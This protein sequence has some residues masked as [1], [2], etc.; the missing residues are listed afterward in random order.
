MSEPTSLTRR[1]ARARDA[2]RARLEALA[3]T[4]AILQAA[5]DAIVTI[6]ARGAVQSFNPA[7]ERMFGYDAGEVI[8]RNVSLLMPPP[9]REEHDGYL[10]RYL[11]TGEQRI[12]GIGREVVARRK[13]GA[14]FPIDLAVSEV[15]VGGERSFMGTLRDISARKAAE[16]ELRRQRDFA[17]SLVDTAPVIVLVLDREGRIVRFNRYMEQ[18]TG[19]SLAEVQGADWF[20]TFL[21]DRDRPGV[22]RIYAESLAGERVRGNVNPILGR[23]GEERL[24][25]WYDT[26]IRAGDGAT[27]GI[28]AIGLDVTEREALEEQFRQAQKM[29][30][31]GR[32]AGGVAH[33]FNTVLASILGYSEVLLDALEEERLRHPVEQV[34]RAAERGAGLTRQLLALSRRERSE[35]QVCDVNAVIDDIRSM[36]DR[37]LREDVELVHDLAAGPAFA[38]IGPG[39]L[40]QVVLNLVVNARDAIE[41]GGRIR[42]STRRVEQGEDVGLLGP[43]EYVGLTVADTGVGMTADVRSRIF[44]PFFTTKAPGKGTGLGLSTV[45]GIVEQV[46]GAIRVETA[47]GEGSTFEVL[48]PSALGMAAPAEAP[49]EQDAPVQGGSEVVLLVEDDSMFR[50]LL[51]EVLQSAGYEVLA[52]EEPRVAIQRVAERGGAIDLLVSDMVM[53]GMS[54]VELARRLLAQ[55]GS[56]KVILMSGYSDEELVEPETLPAHAPLLQKPFSPRQLL[57][58]VR[59]VLEAPPES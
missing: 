17:E 24:I 18:L 55:Q 43:G 58:T 21:P 2:E 56:L 35:P 29:E 1:L 26:P 6:D 44:D 5:V 3:R 32:L 4:E 28:L 19:R 12:I 30:A 45:Y 13:D 16:E 23:G 20:E 15:T 51:E 14:V 8:G 9:Y 31:I 41:G 50:G 49:R 7:A 38:G 42:V 36:F 59:Q 48:I 57:R 46:G 53:P 34:R 10:E 37:L 33:D 27:G 40:E 47:P 39:Q 22:R 54:G 25:E 52:A 11:R